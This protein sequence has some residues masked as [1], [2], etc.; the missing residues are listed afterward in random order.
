M[1]ALEGLVTSAWKK[2]QKQ[3]TI[4][5]SKLGYNGGKWGIFVGAA[6][7]TFSIVVCQHQSCR[8]TSSCGDFLT[9]ETWCLCRSW[10][11]WLST[12]ISPLWERKTGKTEKCLQDPRDC[13]MGLGFTPSG[14]RELCFLKRDYFLW[15]WQMLWPV[16]YSS[17]TERLL[18]PSSA[19]RRPQPGCFED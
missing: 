11:V 3:F 14:S 2:Q 6:P 12:Y 4:L 1:Y 17:W 5:L 7:C 16:I 8:D 10:L 9:T 15:I 19:G 18:A 13:F